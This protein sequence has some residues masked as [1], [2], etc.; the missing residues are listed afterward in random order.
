M[1]I[2]C[3]FS[4]SYFLFDDDKYERDTVK[5]MMIIIIMPCMIFKGL[6]YLRTS[7]YS[8]LAQL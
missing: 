6:L 2:V 8:Q 5:M 7:D 4:S 1:H 3:L